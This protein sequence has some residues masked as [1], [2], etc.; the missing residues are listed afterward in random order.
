M[1]FW[2]D[3]LMDVFGHWIAKTTRLQHDH[4]PKKSSL[5]LCLVVIFT[6]NKIAQQQ[7]QI[8]IYLFY[9]IKVHAILA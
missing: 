2:I 4:E 6:S 3:D 9:R 8:F 5:M 1:S 7:V